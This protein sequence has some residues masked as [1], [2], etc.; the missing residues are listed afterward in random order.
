MIYDA[1][2]IG[3]GAAGLAAAVTAAERGLSVA[4]IE[5]NDRIG[6]KILVTGNG[7]CNLASVLPISG[8]YNTPLTEATFSKVPLSRIKIFFERLGL[9]LREEGSR[10]YPYSNQA[11]SVVNALRGGVERSGVKVFT[12]LA[13]CSVKKGTT[14][15]LDTQNRKL[16]SRNLIF[17]AGSPAGQGVDSIFLIESLGHGSQSFRPALVPVLT[18][19]SFLRGLRG[20]RTEASVTL[21]AD[22][23]PVD[24]VTDEVI[25]KDNGL[26][27]TAIFTLSSAI[28][29]D[30]ESR[31]FSLIMDFAPDFEIEELA[32]ILA[33]KMG[34]EGLFH[35]ELAASLSRYAGSHSPAAIACAAKRF[36]V[37]I[38]GL[39]SF[40][41]AQVSSGGLINEGFDFSTM[42]SRLCPGL[43][44]AGEALDVDGVCGGFNLMWAWASGILAG[45]SVR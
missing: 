43:Y 1:A 9:A 17:S 25:F 14:F 26:S 12:S 45:E 8:K 36:S 3:G 35:K 18:E 28:A 33:G 32:R 34:A 4:L 22:G 7:K 2:I 42:Q 29:R 6:K 24:T 40:D 16:E 10:L 31:S 44:A 38:K 19:T 30:R 27:G 15:V 21:F 37:G 39:S 13:V 20:V 11:S 41:L 23:K 5:K